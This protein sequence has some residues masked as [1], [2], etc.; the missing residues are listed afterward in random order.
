MNNAAQIL[1]SRLSNG[2]RFSSMWKLSAQLCK[3]QTCTSLSRLAHCITRL[4]PNFVL[5]SVY[6]GGSAVDRVNVWMYIRHLS[7]ARP[8]PSILVNPPPTPSVD[9]AGHRRLGVETVEK[10]RTW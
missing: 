1:A 3:Q 5:R 2:L 7:S 10:C 6:F 9:L 4:L 8:A